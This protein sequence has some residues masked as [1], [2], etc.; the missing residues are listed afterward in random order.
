M[1]RPGSDLEGIPYLR[2]LADADAIREGIGRGGKVLAVGAG[3]IGAE[4]GASA[5]ERGLEVTIVEQGAVP[6]ERVFG[7][8]LGAVY[9]DLHLERESS[10]SRARVSRP[11]RATGACSAYVPPTGERSTATS[12]SRVLAWSR[13]EL[14]E[15]SGLQ[16]QNGI[17]VN[18]RLETSAPGVFA[19]GDVANA[20]HPMYGRLRIEHWANALNQTP[21]AA[22]NMLGRDEPYERVP[23]FFPDQYDVGWSTRG[24]RRD[25]TP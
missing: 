15:R 9:R 24:T 2:D 11:S 18:D 20:R 23:Y 16:V 12:S 14:A 25:P 8:E 5:R 22:R 6:L 1:T 17:V 4:V 7:P 21:A 10:S 13:A 3:W 19:A